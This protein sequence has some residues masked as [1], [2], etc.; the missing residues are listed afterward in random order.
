[1]RILVARMPDNWEFTVI[2]AESLNDYKVS[3]LSKDKHMPCFPY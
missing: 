2:G 3:M 1:M